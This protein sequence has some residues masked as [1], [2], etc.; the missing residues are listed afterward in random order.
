[1]ANQNADQKP[2]TPKLGTI[3][4]AKI[5]NAAFITREKIPRVS[6]VR[7]NAINFTIGF[8]KIFIIP[9]TIDKITALIIVTVTPGTK[10]AET[11]IAITETIKC[12]NIFI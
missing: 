11:I 5:I 7:G 10:Y 2:D 6:I 3:F 8:I 1:M 9:R 4:E 12:V